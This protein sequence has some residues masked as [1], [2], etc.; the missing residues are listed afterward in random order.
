MRWRPKDARRFCIGP[1]Y[2]PGRMGHMARSIHKLTSTEKDN[3]MPLDFHSLELTDGSTPTTRTD[4]LI[5][6]F[7]PQVANLAGSATGATVTVPISGLS[8]PASYNVQVTPGSG[9][10]ASVLQSSKTFS[11]FSI[12]LTPL[13]SS[14][15]VA[16][17]AIDVM[18]FA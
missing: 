6:A 3:Q 11:G 13:S 10:V 5:L 14:A 15:T 18:V 8:L 16:A 7:L 2:L 17:G 1:E 12:V 9:V 4:R